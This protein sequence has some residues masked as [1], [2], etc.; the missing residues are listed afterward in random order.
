MKIATRDILRLISRP[1]PNYLAYLFYGHDDGLITER[2]R[3]IA[4]HFTD[5]VFFRVPNVAIFAF[6]IT[7]A[8]A[9]V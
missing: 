1:N 9:L 7:G 5:Q 4:L 6:S 8:G 2:A 3:K